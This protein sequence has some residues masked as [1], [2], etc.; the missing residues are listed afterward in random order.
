MWS[1]QVTHGFTRFHVDSPGLI[2]F[3]WVSLGLTWPRSVSFELNWTHSIP[4]GKRESPDW[5]KGKG[6]PARGNFEP[7]P[8]LHP[9]RAHARTNRNRNRFPGWVPCPPTSDPWTH[10]S[11]DPW[12]MGPWNHRSMDA[13]IN[14]SMDPWM[15][16][17]WIHGPTKMRRTSDENATKIRR[18][19]NEHVTKIRQYDEHTTKL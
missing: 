1:H 12:I 7:V 16:D 4:K 18:T 6:K 2:W 14:E 8:T 13:W 9:E 5:R 19:C 17:P 3:H 10:E 11:M 15:H